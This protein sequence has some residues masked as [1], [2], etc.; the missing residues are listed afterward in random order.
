MILQF[1]QSFFTEALTFINLVFSHHDAAF[2]QIVRRQLNRH[3]V[4]QRQADKMRPHPARNVGQQP[5]PVRQFHPEQGV[6]QHFHYG[7]F[8]FNG[9]F[10]RQVKI[11]GSAS[12]INTVCSKW[13]DS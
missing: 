3:F 8:N 4:A 5:M 9:I 7:A 13:A 6:R 2:R 11:S 12:V 1:S 10:A